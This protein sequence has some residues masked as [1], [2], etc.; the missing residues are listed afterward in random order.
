MG[1]T[2]KAL[3]LIPT[4]I[5][6][7]VLAFLIP[8]AVLAAISALGLSPDALPFLAGAV[9]GLS[10]LCAGLLWCIGRL[11][12]LLTLPVPIRVMERSGFKALTNSS[13]GEVEEITL[14]ETCPRPEDK[15]G[16]SSR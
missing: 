13:G 3:L 15:P 2:C 10:L 4:V 1:A 5:V 8:A 12:V 16:I 6:L 9:V 7:L 14:Q 11:P